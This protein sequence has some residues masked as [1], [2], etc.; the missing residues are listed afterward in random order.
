MLKFLK[1]F[2]LPLVGISA[3][4][5]GDSNQSPDDKVAFSNTNI[6]QLDVSEKKFPSIFSRNIQTETPQLARKFSATANIIS[7]TTDFTKI[8][9]SDWT[10]TFSHLASDISGNFYTR[11]N[12]TTEVSNTEPLTDIY[13]SFS[14]SDIALKVCSPCVSPYDYTVTGVN[15]LDF[16]LSDGAL[17]LELW[18]QAENDDESTIR[19]LGSQTFNWN[20]QNIT[21]A[22]EYKNNKIS[23]TWTQPT[24]AHTRYNIYL[25]NLVS[26]NKNQRLSYVGNAFETDYDLADGAL[27]IQ[28]TGIDAHGESAFSNIINLNNTA[29]V[30]TTDTFEAI[31][32]TN[33]TNQN[34]LANDFDID[35][36]SLTVATQSIG[37]FS[38]DKNGQISID[39]SGNITYLAAQNFN[40]I[41]S[42]SYT[43]VDQLGLESQGLIN[44]IVSNVNDA[45]ITLNDLITLDTDSIFISYADL[46]S[47]DLDLENSPLT[48]ASFSAP[49][50]GSLTPTTGGFN[51][52]TNTGFVGIDTF[53]YSA[54]DADGA[55]SNTSQVFL[56]VGSTDNTL[57]AVDDNF[58]LNED[59]FIQANL[60]ANDLFESDIAIEINFI[61]AVSHG[62]LILGD[63]GSITYTPNA[64]FTGSD[65]FVY[66]IEQGGQ[67]AQALVKLSVNNINDAPQTIADVYTVDSGNIL[68]VNSMLGVLAN[69]TDLES[70]S[71]TAQLGSKT[72]SSGSLDFSQDGSFT[73]QASS[74]FVGTIVFSY[75][76]QDQDGAETE[77]DVMINVLAANKVPVANNSTQTIDEDFVLTAPFTALASDPES[78][79]LTFKISVQPT[80]GSVEI[81][82]S[83]I[84]YTPNANFNGQDSYSFIA[85]DGKDD[86]NE[87]KI[88]ILVNSVNDSPVKVSD[89]PLEVSEGAILNIPDLTQIINDPDQDTLVFSHIQNDITLGTVELIDNQVNYTPPSSLS[90]DTVDSFTIAA[91]DNLGGLVSFTFN[92][93]VKAVNDKPQIQDAEF[94]ITE[95]TSLVI[96]LDDISSDEETSSSELIYKVESVSSGHPIDE[97][98]LISGNTLTY[99]PKLN[100]TQ[101]DILNLS[102]NDGEFTVTANITININPVNDAP[103]TQDA[104]F[105]IIATDQVKIDLSEY[106]TDVDSDSFSF[107]IVD[108]GRTEGEIGTASLSGN[109]LT[110]N[111]SAITDNQTDSIVFI[112]LDDNQLPSNQSSLVIN[113]APETLPR[114]I[115]S[116]SLALENASK[117]ILDGDFAYVASNQFISVY[118]IS[119]KTAPQHII[120]YQAKNEILDLEIGTNL[121]FLA[122]GT[123]GVEILDITTPSQ[124]NLKQ[125]F[126]TE[127]K[128]LDIAMQ[129]EVMYLA[130]DDAGL[131]IYYIGKASETP[132]KL[133]SSSLFANFNQVYSVSYNLKYLVLAT[134]SELIIIDQNDLLNT[135]NSLKYSNYQ[136]PSGTTSISLYDDKLHYSCSAC[137]YVILDIS[138][139]NINQ[140][141]Q[142]SSTTSVSTNQIYQTLD[143]SFLIDVMN[144]NSVKITDLSSLQITPVD[145]NIN[146][147]TGISADTSYIYTVSK[148]TG[149][150]NIIKYRNLDKVII[151][152]TS[153]MTDGTTGFESQFNMSYT[154]WLDNNK[155]TQGALFN[156]AAIVNFN[157]LVSNTAMPVKVDFKINDES[158]YTDSNWPYHAVLTAPVSASMN[159]LISV[160]YKGFTHNYSLPN[161]T[162]EVDSDSD[163]IND[164]AETQIYSSNTEL[165]DSDADGL[166]DTIERLIKTSINAPDTDSDD[167]NDGDEYLAGT[168]PKNDDTTA[169]SLT[170]TSPSDNQF[171]VCELT[172]IFVNYNEAV[173]V[174]DIANNLIKVT[175]SQLNAVTGTLE[176]STDKMSFTFT[177]SSSLMQNESYTVSVSAVKDLAGNQTPGFN[178]GFTTTASI[179]SACL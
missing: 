52:Q 73:Y 45:P 175:D 170:G 105:N 169:A 26:G 136:V 6:N 153:D 70:T 61:Q 15:P 17:T 94:N 22:S 165:I 107:Q 79:P 48:I 112:A 139:S 144:N 159:M 141:T 85:N 173:K 129:G 65:S 90:V 11:F 29:P 7:P 148:Q 13:L 98:T 126:G 67:T 96:T 132:V 111:A 66:Q 80:N 131:A 16:Q 125:A 12:L 101:G 93:N 71:L 31:E 54:K 137:G 106:V 64:N 116:S 176:Q 152:D 83:A 24:D 155:L 119:D 87:A 150:F 113:V 102:V 88:T 14:N 89:V 177:P 104:S 138:Q 2:I 39:I 123:H 27:S 171:E 160:E 9:N 19:L 69:D 166:S 77:Q 109:I 10:T 75:L 44:F 99:T 86:S 95:D 74:D 1:I 174:A 108:N 53:T 163:G 33:L 55:L 92:V 103:V 81:T 156:I 41:D 134:G 32:D 30:A 82:D 76:A 127:G 37:T 51:Y 120:D 124:V 47:N 133:D 143:K 62:V 84:I 72:P 122:L 172:N 114:L 25:E 115:S 140:I 60:I 18:G 158:V 23:L 151:P 117:V 97:I 121:L 4:S 145:L 161:I 43:L 178:L 91:N 3:V 36:H 128:A 34:I 154:N 63:N 38:T 49:L 78:S 135:D 147:V 57:L 142:L 168:D 8:T 110:Y 56:K 42:F 162:L 157:N 118:N 149:Q 50:N 21:L 59:S 179:S 5:C 35:Q 58:T 20:K 167:I 100:D 40:G 130:V 164:L 68:V 28:V 146:E 46:F